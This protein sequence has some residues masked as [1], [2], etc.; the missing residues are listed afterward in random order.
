MKDLIFFF[1]LLNIKL[2]AIWLNDLSTDFKKE[3]FSKVIKETNTYEVKMKKQVL[4]VWH[5]ILMA[6]VACLLFNK[7]TD[8][9]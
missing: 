1:F 6:A 7:M 2:S 3:N 5:F 4:C 8:G 9:L